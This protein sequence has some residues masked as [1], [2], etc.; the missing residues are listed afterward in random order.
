MSDLDMKKGDSTPNP[1]P[2]KFYSNDPLYPRDN[3]GG[4]DAKPYEGSFGDG[5][6]ITKSA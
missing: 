2:A 6:K 4:P 3:S 1:K 5:G